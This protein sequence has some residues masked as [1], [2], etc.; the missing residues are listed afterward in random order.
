MS[1]SELMRATHQVS[2]ESDNPY[3]DFIAE[4][5]GMGKLLKYVKGVWMQGDDEVDMGTELAAVAPELL[6][7]WVRF[8]TTRDEKVIYQLGLVR[9][10]YRPP[11][12]ESL[13]EMDET[14]WST[15]DDGNPRDPWQ[16]Q[17]Y[18]KIIHM[19][20]GE[21]WYYVTQSDGGEKAICDILRLYNPK[22]ATSEVPIVALHSGD[23]LHK[24]K[25]YGRVLVPLFKPTGG[26]YDTGAF[27]PVTPPPSPPTSLP[28]IEDA[29]PLPAPKKK[30]S[31]KPKAE[32][33]FGDD[34]L[35]Y[36]IPY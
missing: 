33:S 14:Q 23:Y 6:V 10:R 13:G 36:D 17:Y 32:P 25:S 19:E 12:R 30:S 26:W 2:P 31:A 16:F 3:A 5:G 22:R 4:F 20:S 29:K 7:G 9:E 28:P 1:K 15:D 34:D 24:N 27:Y 11:P 21:T 8:P 35:D 18:L